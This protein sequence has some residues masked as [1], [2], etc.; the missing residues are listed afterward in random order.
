[1]AD[2]YAQWFRAS[3]PYALAPAAL[4][5]RLAGD[6]AADKLVVFDAA[7]RISNQRH[8]PAEGAPSP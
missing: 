8:L 4:A 5:A 1:M 3:K 6:L 7:A 2:A